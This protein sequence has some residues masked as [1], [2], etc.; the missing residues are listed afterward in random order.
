MKLQISGG[1]GWV[2]FISDGFKITIASNSFSG[3]GDAFFSWILTENKNDDVEVI[4]FQDK[5]SK[6]TK[7]IK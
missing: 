6:I 3:F 1:K 7:V 5:N 2:Y 4:D